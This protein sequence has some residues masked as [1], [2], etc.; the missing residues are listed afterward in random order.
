VKTVAW[1][2]LI[3]AHSPDQSTLAAATNCV[4]GT[5]F[6]VYK[7]NNSGVGRRSTEDIKGKIEVIKITGDHSAVVKLLISLREIHWQ[8]TIRS[9]HQ[10]SR[11]AKSW[12]SQSLDFLILT[13]IPAV[14]VMNS[15]DSSPEQ[16][17]TL[18]CKSVMKQS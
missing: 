13:A 14:T 8:K 4:S 6:S 7:K 9:I 12:K 3:R 16:M 5:T 15:F 17:L 18:Q 11:L 1:S 10:S 2:L